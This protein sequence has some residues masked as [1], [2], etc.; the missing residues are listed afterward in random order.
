VDEKVTRHGNLRPWPITAMPQS[1]VKLLQ[2]L[3][4]ADG[5]VASFN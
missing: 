5:A 1:R 2:L 4:A 3:I